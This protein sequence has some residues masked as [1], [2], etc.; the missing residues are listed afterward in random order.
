M[1]TALILP[2][3]LTICAQSHAAITVPNFLSNAVLQIPAFTFSNFATSSD[4]YDQTWNLVVTSQYVA[5]GTSDFL[6]LQFEMQGWP[7]VNVP[8]PF[9]YTSESLSGYSLLSVGSQVFDAPSTQPF[10]SPAVEIPFT[11]GQ[12]L[13]VHV[14]ASSFIGYTYRTSISFPTPQ[15]LAGVVLDGNRGSGSFVRLT[16]MYVVKDQSATITEVSITAVPEPASSVLVGAPVLL[17]AIIHR[18]IKYVAGSRH[19]LENVN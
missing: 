8:S 6:R 11:Y 15:T 3:L 5:A 18:R 19:R 7:D 1:R 9:G 2:L 14:T 4:S 16:N 13:S 12:V 17:L 10:K